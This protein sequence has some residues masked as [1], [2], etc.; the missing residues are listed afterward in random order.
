MIERGNILGSTIGHLQ[1]W[2]GAQP[3]LPRKRKVLLKLY[4]EDIR[5]F[6]LNDFVTFVGILESKNFDDGEVDAEGNSQMTNEDPKA[7]A[8]EQ[9]QDD[10]DEEKDDP[11]ICENIERIL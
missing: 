7:A 4:G 2:T 5:A 10:Q 6:K 1:E 8:D 9:D 3:S 11:Q